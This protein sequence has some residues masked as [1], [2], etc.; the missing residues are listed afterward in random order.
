[1]FSQLLCVCQ[2]GI[3]TMDAWCM[4]MT[5]LAYTH[6]REC[7]TLRVTRDAILFLPMYNYYSSIIFSDLLKYRFKI[8][9]PLQCIGLSFFYHLY[10]FSFL[11]H[12]CL[13]FIFHVLVMLLNTQF[14][15][16]NSMCI[17]NKLYLHTSCC[18]CLGHSS[19]TATLTH[20]QSV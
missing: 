14:D 15:F 13:C 12:V 4:N 19:I 20:V 3:R 11:I 18:F 1:M 2:F 7:S 17:L 5:L 6:M 9:F 16:C 10:I 8:V